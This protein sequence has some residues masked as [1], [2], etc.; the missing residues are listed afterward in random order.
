[1]KLNSSH[2]KVSFHDLGFAPADNDSSDDDDVMITSNSSS[3]SQLPQLG[4]RCKSS[5]MLEIGKKGQ[6]FFFE[7][8][9]FDFVIDENESMKI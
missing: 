5:L 9:F 6:N 7:I 8:P 4:I 1:M 2:R 3:S